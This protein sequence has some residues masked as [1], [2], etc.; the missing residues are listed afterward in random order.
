MTVQQKILHY[1]YEHCTIV[2]PKPCHCCGYKFGVIVVA[3]VI[4]AVV[5]AVVVFGLT[6]EMRAM[7]SP[8]IEDDD[9]GH[10]GG[11]AVVQRTCSL[12]A[13]GVTKIAVLGRK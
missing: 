3:A 11:A 9:D 6:D 13:S 7:G 10:T 1:K 8:G 4:G 2:N 5:V 12:E